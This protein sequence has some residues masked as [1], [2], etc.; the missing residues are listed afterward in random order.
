MWSSSLCAYF[1]VYFHIRYLPGDLF[2]N[3]LVFS[4][5]EVTAYAIG[6]YLTL[7]FG[8]KTSLVSSYMMA[9]LSTIVYIFIRGD[10]E[11]KN[12]TAVALAAAGF[13]IVWAC[14]INWNGNAA[15]F[16][17]IY[18]SSTNGICNFFG[19]LMSSISP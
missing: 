11:L 9:V 4:C 16:P 8:M 12:Y 17:V 15:L 3:T 18:S 6:S 13:G 19:R 7:K 2:V 14:N 1:T 5:C 10:P